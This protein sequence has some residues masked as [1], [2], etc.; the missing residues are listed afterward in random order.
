[1]SVSEF[2]QEDYNVIAR[3]YALLEREVRKRCDNPE[4]LALIDKAFRFANEAHKNVRRRSGEPYMRH[5]IAVA[6]IVCTE[7]GLGYKSI[8]AALLHDVVEDTFHTSDEIRNLFGDKIASLV[9]GLTKIKTILD[10]QNRANDG[11][12]ASEHIQAENLKRIL[13]TLN[14]DVRI[15][16]IKLADRLHNCRTIEYMPAHKRDKILSE[17][18]F[19]FIPLAHRLGLYSVK[20]QMEDI[21]LRYKE[22]DAYNEIKNLTNR[23][24][25]DKGLKIDRFMAPIRAALLQG[26]FDFEIRK[27]IKTPYSIWHKMRTKNVAFEQVYD[28]Y[29]VRIIFT[30]K[31]D[32]RES[33]RDQCY[34][35]FSIITGLYRY[36]PDRVRDWVK[37]P[38]SNGYEALHCTLMGDDGMWIE[39]QIRSRRM[40][41]IAEKGIAA[42]WAYKEAGYAGD[43]S[44]DQWLR[45]VKE[46]LLSSDLDA[47]ELLDMIHEDLTAADIMVFTPAGEQKTVQKGYTALDFAYQIHTEVGNHAI[48]AKAN[49]RLVPLS[50]VLKGGDQ[51]E[52]ITAEDAHPQKEWLQFLQGRHA[53]SK[54]MDYFKSVWGDNSALWRE[55]LSI[56]LK[57]SGVK[58]NERIL[59]GTVAKLRLSNT[60]ELLFRY[61]IGQISYEAIEKAA[62]QVPGSMKPSSPKPKADKGKKKEVYIINSPA[63]KHRYVF[64]NCC[65]P[66][67][68]D[69]VIGFITEDG[70]VMVHSKTCPDAQRLASKFADTIVMPEWANNEDQS[71]L[72]RISIQGIDRLGLI[73][74]ITKTI[75]VMGLNIAKL[76][77]GTGNGLFDGFIDLYVHDKSVLE[78]LRVKVLKVN[79]IQSV[80]RVES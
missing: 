33:E 28:L 61:S 58:L 2:S 27:R 73:S 29:A 43:S 53:K 1:M 76:N 41:D 42:H 80:N 22:P 34:H 13:F 11:Y 57:A 79:G 21:W 78:D 10:D 59:R 48:A 72:V 55:N 68:G 25:S 51:I 35:I 38:K 69:P 5:P 71:F 23:D 75:S 18:M 40:D 63:D 4:Q 39:V 60:D 65:R 16:L 31:A 66:I 64:S 3:D 32:S 50:Y 49:M 7:I 12:R 54:C 9:E 46:I 19:I 67:A 17:T 47:L 37:H 14:D 45:K 6:L 36:K 15:V 24:L 26:G 20:S 44:I 77:L 62:M 70:A 52:I 56:K 30:P 8:C 74:D